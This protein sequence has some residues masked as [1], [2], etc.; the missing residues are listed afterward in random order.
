MTERKYRHLR[1]VDLYEISWV[2]SP[3]NLYAQIIWVK[4]AD[5]REVYSA[6]NVE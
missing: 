6:P 3:A 4:D 1:K 2:T 5:G